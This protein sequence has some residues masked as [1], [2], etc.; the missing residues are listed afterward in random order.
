MPVC[1]H[2]VDFIDIFDRDRLVILTNDSPNVLTEFDAEVH[3]VLGAIIRRSHI[4]PFMQ[5][6]A[7]EMNIRTARLP[8]DMFRRFRTSKALPLDQLTDILLEVRR[9]R[10]WNKAFEFIDG[11]KLQ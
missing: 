3:Y 10:D 7:K 6:K 4:N 5:A 8:F 1:V 11:N 9:N 2:H